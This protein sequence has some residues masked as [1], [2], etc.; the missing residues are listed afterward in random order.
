M[1]SKHDIDKKRLLAR[2]TFAVKSLAAQADWLE[3]ALYDRGGR[4]HCKVGDE[5]IEV[6]TDLLARTQRHLYK[7][8]QDREAA[9]KAL[10]DSHEWL[11]RRQRL[12]DEIKIVSA[13]KVQQQSLNYAKPEMHHLMN[14]LVLAAMTV[15][16][17]GNVGGAIVERGAAASPSLLALMG[18][19]ALPLLARTFSAML[20]GTVH[21]DARVERLPAALR[22]AELV[23]AYKFGAANG[24]DERATLYNRLLVCKHGTDLA[25]RARKAWNAVRWGYAID[26]QS[27]EWLATG[28]S[29]AK[30]VEL[31]ENLVRAEPVRKRIERLAPNTLRWKLS[32]K[33]QVEL[34][35]EVRRSLGAAWAHAIETCILTRESDLPLTVASLL[36][37]V[38]DTLESMNLRGESFANAWRHVFQP[39]LYSMDET[40][41]SLRGDYLR[42]LDAASMPTWQ[43]EELKSKNEWA[44]CNKLTTQFNH[45][46]KPIVGLLNL[47][48]DA[49]FVRRCFEDRMVGPLGHHLDALDAESLQLAVSAGTALGGSNACGAMHA[50]IEAVRAVRTNARSRAELKQIVALLKHE[51]PAIDDFKELVYLCQEWPKLG[52]RQG[53]HVATQVLPVVIERAKQ[54]KQWM[55]KFVYPCVMGALILRQWTDAEQGTLWTALVEELIKNDAALNA[56]WYVCMSAV[57]IACYFCEGDEKHLRQLMESCM[58]KKYYLSSAGEDWECLANLSRL[59][60]VLE[61]VRRAFVHHPG[62]CAALFSQAKLAYKLGL[63]VDEVCARL[64]AEPKDCECAVC[65]R[66]TEFGDGVGRHWRGLMHALDCMGRAHEL[67]HSIEK[68][69]ALP[70]SFAKELHYLEKNNPPAGRNPGVAKRIEKL[71]FYKKFPMTLRADVESQIRRELEKTEAQTYVAA[72]TWLLERAIERKCTAEQ[73]GMLGLS[74]EELFDLLVLRCSIGRDRNRT[75]LKRL[76]SACMRGDTEWPLRQPA[77]RAYLREMAERGFDVETWVSAFPAYVKSPLIHD[78]VLKISIEQNPIEVLKMGV[79]F[80]TCLSL[81]GIN[82]FSSIANAT[83]VNKRVIY[84]RDVEGKVVARKLIALSDEWRLLG[85]YTYTDSTWSKERQEALS[86]AVDDYACA[87]AGACGIPLGEG[88]EVRTLVSKSWYDDGSQGW[89]GTCSEVRIRAVLCFKR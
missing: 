11:E 44:V 80:D 42:L 10:G 14:Q 62:G 66:G 16:A 70:E 33:Q 54:R 77:N 45:D 43:D 61:G 5:F 40:E 24:A 36:G 8:R 19:D 41:L 22:T 73:L 38:I 39:L 67:P 12:L 63:A 32:A 68:L 69:I 49:G 71:R 37:H 86:A 55:P 6:N 59:P 23:S 30:L 9:E 26:E 3:A 46:L 78:G 17:G 72:T 74:R 20:L 28:A 79:Y 85:Y 48:R 81:D 2:R 87:F 84:A 65:A 50:V 82:A 51:R 1:P 29:G 31:L 57:R 56:H 88:E 53:F 25:A 21:K 27:L 15:C 52:I 64:D 76:L 34:L 4:L 60:Q 18:D 83:D 7:I 89:T 13:L 58:S 75:E 35:E 47:C